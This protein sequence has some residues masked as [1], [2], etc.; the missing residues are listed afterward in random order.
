MPKKKSSGKT[1]KLRNYNFQGIKQSGKPNKKKLLKNST[2]GVF[3]NE[4]VFSNARK[5]D[6]HT[7]VPYDLSTMHQ[8]DNSPIT[9][10]RFPLHAMSNHDK[11]VGLPDRIS[12]LLR[13]GAADI[14]HISESEKKR[15]LFERMGASLQ[16]QQAGIK[17]IAGVTTCHLCGCPIENEPECEHILP[18]LLAVFFYVLESVGPVREAQEKAG[19]NRIY[20]DTISKNNYL[21]A[22]QQ[23]NGAKS[24]YHPIHHKD[25]NF[26]L[27]EEALTNLINRIGA[28][29][30][31]F[32]CQNKPSIENI[33]EILKNEYLF[34]IDVINKECEQLK[35]IFR[36]LGI[37]DVTASI[38]KYYYSCLFLYVDPEKLCV[39]TPM[40][41]ENKAAL[42]EIRRKEEE[43]DNKRKELYKSIVEEIRHKYGAIKNALQTAAYVNDEELDETVRTQ[44]NGVLKPTIK[45]LV[46]KGRSAKIVTKNYDDQ[47]ELLESSK[48]PLYD[49]IIA[50]FR[51]YAGLRNTESTDVKL[52]QPMSKKFVTSL[53][54]Y[55]IISFG[56]SSWT[57]DL[58]KNQQTPKTLQYLLAS[59][60]NV[61][62]SCLSPQK[63]LTLDEL[64]ELANIKG[65]GLNTP[66]LEEHKSFCRDFIK[67][68]NEKAMMDILT[69]VSATPE[70]EEE[71]NDAGMITENDKFAFGLLSNASTGTHI[72][73]M[74]PANTKT[75]EQR[76]VWKVSPIKKGGNKSKTNKKQNHCKTRKYH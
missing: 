37:A 21:W 3:I 8:S 50:Q 44:I 30:K 7:A 41:E 62:Q 59:T 5:V 12:P 46:T 2:L 35:K 14:G 13:M 47:T 15:Q 48:Q 69:V 20:L 11:F 76:H 23:C 27:N 73:K 34:H 33:R 32:R 68:A 28:A 45:L 18:A 58:A 55:Y 61:I 53:T 29:S 4:N 42:E 19:G 40:T 65:I 51:N 64:I 9:C 25:D 6:P 66:L 38:I 60:L 17:F 36:E 71:S 31:S 16:C 67:D 74:I 1:S 26:Y 10:V 72:G 24:N 43:E 63:L 54:N 56:P 22:H 70:K 57:T 39:S 52:K 75:G 49:I